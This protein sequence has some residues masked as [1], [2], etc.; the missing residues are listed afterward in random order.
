MCHEK[1]AKPR[2]GNEARALKAQAIL[3]TLTKYCGD[4]VVDGAWLD[5]GCGSG[6]IAASLASRVHVVVGI[7][8]EPWDAWED[9]TAALSNLGFIV[10]AFDG[11]EFPATEESMDV[12]ICNQVYEHVINPQRLVRNIN[13]ILRPGG[14]C[15]FAGPNLLWPVEPHVFWPFVH[16]LPRKWAHAVMRAL[17]SRRT[18]ELDAFSTNY[19]T[20][21]RWFDDAGFEFKSGIGGRI[22][23]G[24][25]LRGSRRL[26]RLADSI[27]NVLYAALTPFSPTFVFILR[28][29]NHAGT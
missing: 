11:E 10:G 15:Y 27:P 4:Q 26:S 25:E 22:Q 17:G 5:V 7:D 14:V 19:W 23:S 21:T 13:R 2:W 24:L 28:K 6:G 9:A 16:W 20:L 3:S 18:H 8:P 29:R 12:V 1:A